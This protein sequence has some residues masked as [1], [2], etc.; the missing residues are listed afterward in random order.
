MAKFMFLYRGG[1]GNPEEMSPED[2]QQVM[3]KWM[4][5]IQGGMEAGW[6]VD[7]GDAL[8]ATGKVVHTDATITDGPFAESKE[9][10]G[11][12]SMVQADSL[13]EAAKLTKGCPIFEAGG[14]VEVR[15]LVV[16]DEPNG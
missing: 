4:T 9:L 7:G 12:F 5:W 10:V 8:Q 1:E 16:F 14:K 11:G 6:M 3:Q 2:M 13:D 15:E